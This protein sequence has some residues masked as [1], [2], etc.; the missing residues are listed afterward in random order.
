MKNSTTTYLFL[1]ALLALW[2]VGC[3][4]SGP[5]KQMHINALIEEIFNDDRM[6]EADIRKK[7]STHKTGFDVDDEGFQD[8]LSQLRTRTIDHPEKLVRERVLPPLIEWDFKKNGSKL[9]EN[10]DRKE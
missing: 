9:P 1:A 4:P 10:K 8:F 7:L 5:A 6:N 3:A 2:V